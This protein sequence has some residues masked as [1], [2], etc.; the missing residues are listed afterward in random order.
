M[1]ITKNGATLENDTITGSGSI[2]LA[3]TLKVTAV[4]DALALGDSY[5]LFT[6]AGGL[7]GTFSAYDLPVLPSGL[8]WDTSSLAINGTITVANFTLAP[9]FDPPS[10]AY[11]GAQSV[12]IT[13]EPGATIYYT[14]DGTAPTISSPSGASPISGVTIPLNST[15][16]LRAFATKSGLGDSS[17]TSATF[18]TIPIGVWNVDANGV[19]SQSDNWLT[20]A[21]PDGIG[22]AVDFFTLPQSGVSTVTL[23]S[24]RTVGSMTFGNTNNFDWSV[25][26]SGSS[27][28]TLAVGSGTPTITVQDS[29]TTIAP[30][31]GGTQGFAKAGNGTLVLTGSNTYTGGTTL[32]AGVLRIQNNNALGGG[33]GGTLTINQ[34]TLE[35]P[36]NANNYTIANP[37]TVVNG[38]TATIK[39]TGNYPGTWP[40]LFISGAISNNGD[41]TLMGG[42]NIGG[43]D[44]LHITGGITGN[45]PTIS[46]HVRLMSTPCTWNAD[47]TITLSGA[48]DLL[49]LRST[50]EVMPA[51]TTITVNA[52]T[53]LLNGVNGTMTQTIKAL[54]GTG[55]SV[56]CDWGANTLRIGSGN[57][58]GSYG[59]I[60]AN[61]AGTIP[62]VLQ[63]EKIGNG[64][65]TFTGANTYTG[66]TTITG[67]TLAVGASN[68]LPDTSAI[69]IGAATLSVGASATDSTG[70]LDVTAAATISLGS[71]SAISFA[72]SSAVDWS[73]GTLTITGGF[74]SGSSLRF[75]NN[76]AGLTSIQLGLISCEG[77]TNFG[78]DANGYLTASSTAT[79]YAWATANG[80]LGGPTGDSDNDGISN[81]VEYALDLNPSGSDGSA[82]TYNSATGLISFTKRQSA[83]ENGDLTYIIQV[84]SDL[85]SWTNEVIHAPGD[86]NASIST[87]LI[88]DGPKKFA[89]LTVTTSASSP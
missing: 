28:L 8:T 50:S 31:L 58:S 75:G 56:V 25:A 51:S 18:T 12:T 57:G 72:N 78:L 76:N 47:S 73:G 60:L 26:S 2:S 71:D 9:S 24:N 17:E 62:P 43:R 87:T 4:G 46:G 54:N 79:F 68:A 13:S 3:G 6:N 80:I 29:I 84:S 20:N 67:G 86:A 77:F 69:S 42:P 61:G 89:R 14:T 23:D 52:G 36:A 19:W 83:V 39:A 40:N 53:M 74:V 65:Q 10:G 45:A 1:D 5:T 88:P 21:V 85:V 59:G 41:L 16:T 15:V 48:S 64:V 33:A 27:V 37:V 44:Q 7:S 34:G 11:V 66:S 49:E 81:L 70:S 63:I 35:F 32:D 30:V 22:V 55:G 38:A 82:G